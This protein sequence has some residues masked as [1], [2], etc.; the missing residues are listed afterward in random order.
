MLNFTISRF[1]L[2]EVFIYENYA[3]S[4]IKD[5]EESKLLGRSEN[6]FVFVPPTMDLFAFF[7]KSKKNV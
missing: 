3:H 6:N 2:Q 5:L 1:S 4:L 7:Y